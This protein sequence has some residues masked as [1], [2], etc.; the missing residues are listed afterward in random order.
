MTLREKISHLHRRLGFGLSHEDLDAQEKLGLTRVVENLIDWEKVDEEFSVSPYEFCWRT[1]S[2]EEADLGAYRFRAWW[3][4]R[5]LATKR[6]MQEKMTLFWHSH[7]AV[8][9]SKVE[10]GP[11]MLDYVNGLRAHAN[12]S[13]AD[14]LQTASQSPAMMR[15]LDM[16]RS[17]RGNPNENFGREVMELLTLGIGN[18][19]EDDVK[20][21]SRALTGWGYVHTY[22]E[23]PGNADDKLKLSIKYSR[24]FSAFAE[25]PALHDPSEK[26]ILGKKRTWNGEEVLQMLAQHPATS[27]FIA[28]KLAK[29]FVTQKPEPDYV[30]KLAG[31]FRKSKGDIK[32]VLFAM[33]DSKEFW[34]EKNVRSIPSSP[35]DYVI[36]VGRKQTVGQYLLGLRAKDATPLT[37]IPQPALDQCGYAAYRMDRA[38][39]LLMNPPNV[40]GW[41]WGDAWIT[42]AAMAERMQFLGHGIEQKERSDLA[43]ERAILFASRVK[44][45]DSAHFVSRFAEFYDVELPK[46]KVMILAAI[47]DK[48]GGVKVLE[49]RGTWGGVHYTM[50]RNLAAA[51]EMHLC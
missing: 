39:L 7:F 35:A 26:T 45:T 17:E 42:P 30:E 36:G 44:L 19:T 5:M 32:A 21:V 37:Q 22:Y 6:P 12:G 50:L 24:P 18:Y 47:L 27:R 48:F 25:M 9:D 8:S 43:S 16:N 3:I 2:K 20:E 34:D 1:S 23:Q 41:E 29:T 11:M 51:P 40:A 33:V 13:F 14:L 38:G 31:A 49:N 28:G 10:D 15:Y 46:E 4:M